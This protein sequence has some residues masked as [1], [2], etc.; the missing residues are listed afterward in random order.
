MKEKHFFTLVTLLSAVM[1]CNWCTGE[2]LVMGTGMVA[3]R[4]AMGF[5]LVES[6][7]W[8]CVTVS[9]SV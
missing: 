6:D 4:L 3:T 7:V 2:G 9:L 1:L 5:I 8:K